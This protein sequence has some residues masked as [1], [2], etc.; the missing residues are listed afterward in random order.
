MLAGHS[1]RRWVGVAHSRSWVE[2]V[3]VREQ[4]G[5]QGILCIEVCVFMGWEK[6]SKIPLVE[7]VAHFHGLSKVQVS[8]EGPVLFLR[9]PGQT[10][11]IWDG[12]DTTGHFWMPRCL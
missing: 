8:L 3:G 7:G 1:C 4:L 5:V 10:G 6:P 11:Q 2:V 9:S 12:L